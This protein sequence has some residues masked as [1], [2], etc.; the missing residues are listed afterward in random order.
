MV[1]R[2]GSSAPS[3]LL[4]GTAKRGR[5]ID[6][7]AAVSVEPAETDGAMAASYG[8]TKRQKE[9][10]RQEKQREKQL[11][12]KQRREQRAAS[13]AGRFEHPDDFEGSPDLQPPSADEPNAPDPRSVESGHPGGETAKN[14]D[15]NNDTSDSDGL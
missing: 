2:D 7:Y 5:C 10:Q 9:R 6:H 4:D 8:F 14:D 12:R 15:N 1:F 11:K 3:K 13:K